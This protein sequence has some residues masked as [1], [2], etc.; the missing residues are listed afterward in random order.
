VSY[1]SSTGDTTTA[2][3]DAAGRLSTVSDPQGTTTTSYDNSSEHR[4]LPTTETVSNG[5]NPAVT[6]TGSYDPAGHLT[7]QNLPGGITTTSSY[8]PAGEQ[9]GLAYS[10]QVTT[11]NPDGSTTVNPNGS[12]L[13]W[14][15]SYDAA[16]RVRREW[17]PDGSAFANASGKVG[18]AVG[19]DRQYSYDQAG[20]LTEVDDRTAAATGTTVD[21]STAASSAVPC[22]V[23]AYTFNGAGDRTALTTRIGTDGTCPTSGGTTTSWAYN[24]AHQLTGG[25]TYDDL[26]RATTIPAADTPNGT[27]AGDLTIG[28]YDTDAV[29]TITH[30]GTTS[31]YALDLAGRRATTT[32][33]PTSG[34]PSTTLV[35]H[36]DDG[37]DNPTW[38]ET[39]TSSGNTVTRYLSG[40]GGALADSITGGTTQLSLLNPEGDAVTTVT[41]P[42]VGPATAINA[43][44][45]YTEYGT[46]DS[47][48]AT[49]TVGGPAGY[50]WLGSDQRGT[51]TTGLVLMGARLY[52]PATGQFTSIDP[53]YGGNETAYNYPNDPINS[54]DTTGQ[55]SYTVNYDIGQ[56]L[57]YT[58]RE[59]F[60]ALDVEAHFSRVFPIAGAASSLKLGE[61]MFLRPYW[62][63]P[64]RV[65]VTSL[66]PMGW[67]FTPIFP[68]PDQ[69]GSYISF[70]FSMSY[71][72]LYLQVHGDVSHA[73]LRF[74]VVGWYF[75]RW[76]AERTWSQFADNLRSECRSSGYCISSV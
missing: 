58:P 54:S 31:T 1:T 67:T 16:G 9:T 15:R 45:D 69:G 70:K 64:F 3:Y 17:T 6:F 32:T 46:P 19:Y 28:Y 49:T 36:Y 38:T 18:N 71:G 74:S 13:A 41:V 25:Y 40:L 62:V 2:T 65:K 20:R 44:S 53:V 76:M 72:D 39:R 26:G 51:D 35:Q 42:S 43:W 24:S 30:N 10:G 21:P 12:W 66:S 5:T 48:S 4:G 23:R 73:F 63:L 27:A 52:N 11:T 47:A 8:D 22:T 75:Y 55:M 60:V 68:H 7:V 59:F 14:T 33:G 34:S 56:F 50:A 29:H 37:G 61:T 57:P